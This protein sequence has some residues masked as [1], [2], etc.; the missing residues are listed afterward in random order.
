MEDGAAAGEQ[1]E[2]FDQLFVLY[3]HGNSNKNEVT[4]EYMILE[5]NEYVHTMK[6]DFST[7]HGLESV[8]IQSNMSK[9]L[10][11]GTVEKSD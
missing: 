1:L 11:A 4:C 3:G 8:F 5:A 7:A 10:T 9:E 2:A 6:L